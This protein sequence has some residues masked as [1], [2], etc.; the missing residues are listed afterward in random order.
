MLPREFHKP[1][2]SM[3]FNFRPIRLTFG[4]SAPKSKKVK[5]PKA[6]KQAKKEAAD[7]AKP[8]REFAATTPKCQDGPSKMKKPRKKREPKGPST[9]DT[10][11]TTSGQDG[12]AVTKSGKPRKKPLPMRKAA[13]ATI[14]S[15][16]TATTIQVRVSLSRSSS[17]K[18]AKHPPRT[19]TYLPEHID[20][21]GTVVWD[22]QGFERMELSA[23]PWIAGVAQ[24]WYDTDGDPSGGHSQ[25]LID[26]PYDLS[27]PCHFLM[28]EED[29]HVRLYAGGPLPA[30]FLDALGRAVSIR[31]DGEG[32]NT[33]VDSLLGEADDA[34]KNCK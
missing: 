18:G 8:G 10:I 16:T 22:T 24:H 11:P 30:S 19:F 6:T 17:L 12:S 31:R 23:L 27:L 29:V 5:K 21:L 15:T 14:P 34:G 25:Q 7:E 32:S 26:S 2:V 33:G 20:A 3:R 1:Q 4:V 28:D 13:E 9:N